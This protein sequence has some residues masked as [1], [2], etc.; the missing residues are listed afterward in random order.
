MGVQALL[1]GAVAA[2]DEPV[3][4][5]EILSEAE[6]GVLLQRFNATDAAPSEL[7]H[8]EQTVPG[9][10]EH[11]AAVKPDAPAVVFEARLTPLPLSYFVNCT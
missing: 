3:D 7:L 6:A 4:Q 8:L 11:W 1:K 9:V 5:L 2:L 10:L